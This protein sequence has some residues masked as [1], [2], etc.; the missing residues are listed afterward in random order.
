MKKVWADSALIGLINMFSRYLKISLMYEVFE[1]KVL[2]HV[3]TVTIPFEKYFPKFLQL[4][5]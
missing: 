1:D 3:V 2:P 5:F 4:F